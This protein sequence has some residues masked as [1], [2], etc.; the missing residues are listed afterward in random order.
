[1]TAY[2]QN[3]LDYFN[4]QPHKPQTVA[5]ALFD[6]PLGTAALIVEE[7]KVWSDSGDALG[8]DADQGPGPDERHVYLMTDTAGS[9]VWFYRR[10]ADDPVG[11]RP[12]R[13][14]TPTGFAACPR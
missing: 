7:L 8:P 9:A 10:N 6:H 3:E 11:A 1:M 5:F 12:A 4:E 13:I 2:R 14:M